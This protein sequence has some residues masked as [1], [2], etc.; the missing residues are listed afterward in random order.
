MVEQGEPVAFQGHL[1]K[2]GSINPSFKTRWFVL[3]EL[4]RMVYFTNNKANRPIGQLSLATAELVPVEENEVRRQ[5]NWI[6]GILAM[7]RLTHCH[8]SLPASTRSSLRSGRMAGSGFFGARRKKSTP[9]G[10]QL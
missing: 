10:S 9:G 2:R 7:R 8:H 1:Q 3:T 6:T 5:T 4:G